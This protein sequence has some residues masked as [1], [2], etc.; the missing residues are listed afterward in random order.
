MTLVGI[1]VSAFQPAN[2]STV[3]PAD[4]V[5]AKATEGVGYVSSTCVAQLDGALSSGKRAGFYHFISTDNPV[6]QADFFCAQTAGFFWRAVPF[7]D[8]EGAGMALGVAGARA[9]IDRVRSNMGVLPP[10]YMSLSPASQSQYRALVDAGLWVAYGANYGTPQGYEGAPASSSSGV[11]PSAQLRQFTSAGR[12]P[13]YGASL[14]LDVFYGDGPTWD[15]IATGHNT[16]APTPLEEDVAL[17]QAI[18]RPGQPV[19]LFAPGYVKHL[20]SSD[21]VSAAQY[22]TRLGSPN[23]SH[24]QEFQDTIWNYGL[25]EYSV[26]QVLEIAT[27]LNPDGTVQN[28]NRGGMLL[29]SW[30]DV[31]KAAEPTLGAEQIASMA[32]AVVSGVLA[33][34][35]AGTTTEQIEA[36]VKAG[37]D[38]LTLKAA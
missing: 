35:P 2:I 10:I 38:G 30:N 14:D 9:F 16:S 28:Y 1:D 19:Y 25:E 17:V 33:G 7:L 5:I 3:V 18:D 22:T 37:L 8:W 11:W 29:A 20:A 6:A 27:N 24:D 15:A 36:A 32:S 31:R 13:G 21:Q 34:L 12:L 26:D 23:Q 4:F